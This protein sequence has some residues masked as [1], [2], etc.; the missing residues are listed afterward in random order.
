MMLPGDTTPRRECAVAAPAGLASRI[1][2]R[3]LPFR[4]TATVRRTV[5]AYAMT[6][7]LLR[8]LDVVETAIGMQGLAPVGPPFVRLHRLG[9]ELDL[10]IGI[11]L[12]QPIEPAGEVRPSSLPGGPAVHVLRLG[13]LARAGTLRALTAYLARH[14]L[15]QVGSPWECILGDPDR[16]PDPAAWQTDLYV[17]VAPGHAS[18][19]GSPR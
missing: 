4:H 8:G 6:G 2:V 12:A 9:E 14:G 18:P 17:P 3:V 19:A 13:D 7:E 10:E 15:T 16:C 5:A 1:E 11:P